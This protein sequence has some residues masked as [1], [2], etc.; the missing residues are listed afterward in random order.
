MHSIELQTGSRRGT[1]PVTVAEMM[2]AY[3]DTGSNRFDR[4]PPQDME[5]EQCVLGAM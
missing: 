5:A 3:E 1:L 2:R 4:T